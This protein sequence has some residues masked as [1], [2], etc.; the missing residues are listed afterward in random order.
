[1]S[2]F[3][4]M[5]TS[6]FYDRIAKTVIESLDQGVIPWR[7]PWKGGISNCP[8]T[9]SG[10]HYRGFNVWHLAMIGGMKGYGSPLWA[11]LNQILKWKGRVK[12]EEFGKVT[13]TFKFGK[14]SYVA[15]D[16]ETGEEKKREYWY[17]KVFEVYNL[18]QTEGVKLPPKIADKLEPEVRDGEPV[19]EIWEC[20]RMIEGY[21]ADGPGIN[22]HGMRAAYYPAADRIEMP[23][24]DQFESTE[25]YYSTLFHE[26]CHSTGHKSRLNRKEVGT[27]AFGRGGYG[28]E[29]LVAEFGAS[30]C[31]GVAGIDRE[32][33]SN[34]VAYIQHWKDAIGA[35]PRMV[36]HA[37]SAAQKASD[38][39]LSVPEWKPEKEGK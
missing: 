6:E 4:R 8:M 29:E 36:V 17:V 35:D 26:L 14:G 28:K 2:G 12:R 15:E 33:L 34:S 25:E 32:T 39:V 18:D 21:L 11:S 37:A 3:Y 24:R 38:L 7:K 10:N 27:E 22:D 9:A 19:S 5:K 16:E 20:E 13:N 30:Y 1:M 23:R 31:C